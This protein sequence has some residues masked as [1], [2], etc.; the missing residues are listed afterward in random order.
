[1]KVADQHSPD[2]YQQLKQAL[3]ADI[4]AYIRKNGHT[5]GPLF[6]G[7]AIALLSLWACLYV[8]I[9]FFTPI[10][11]AGVFALAMIWGLCSLLIIFNIG[12]DAVHGV[13]SKRKGVN[14]C[15]QYTFNL[16][17]GNAYSWRL[18]HNIAHHL[19]TNIEGRDFDT[20]L[21]PLMRLSPR[22]PYLKSYRWQHLTV[23]LVYP[24]LSI[25]IITVADFKIFFQ[26]QNARL[27]DRHPLEEWVIV[28]ASKIYYVMLIV[29]V[30][31]YV[32]GFS[33]NE[34]LIAF[35]SFQLLNGIIIAF[36]FMPSH[37]F[38]GSEYYD[39]RPAPYHWIEHQTQTTMDLSPNDYLTSTLL[40]GLNL[41]ISHHLYAHFCHTHYFQLSKIIKKRLTESG[42]PYNEMPFPKAWVAHY[43]YLLYVRKETV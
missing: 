1:M 18:K 2:R 33:L 9:I 43:K 16:V 12:H 40:G 27:V 4:R 10:A 42:V 20:D 38:P 32:G 11:T 14:D 36:V 24:L 31:M 15:L 8:W 5:A 37:Y 7:K 19:H 22:S 39:E 30:P 34:I 28:I 6:W 41:N 25:L 3:N 26:T 21:S 29:I 23:F 13:I 17:G 35:I